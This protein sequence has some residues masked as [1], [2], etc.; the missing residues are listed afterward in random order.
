MKPIALSC[1]VAVLV[2]V[3]GGACATSSVRRTVT[4]ENERFTLR[5]IAGVQRANPLVPGQNIRVTTLRK[6][7]RASM[8]LVQIQEGEVPHIHAVH[9]L[10]VFV[11]RGVGEMTLG[12][13][14]RPVRDG[15]VIHIPAGVRHYFTNRGRQ[16]SMAV[17][18]FS[19]AFDGTDSL[20]V[21]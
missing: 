10:S 4:W 14:T 21:P 19:P 11:V 18:V 1:I 9:D 12:K 20:N 16:P 3:L 7:D 6:T 5:E 13:E 15:D 2:A 17:V 8:H